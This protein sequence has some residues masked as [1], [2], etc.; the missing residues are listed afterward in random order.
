VQIEGGLMAGIIDARM[1]AEIEG[2]F[3]VF[4]IGFRINKFWKVWKW[5]PVFAAMPRMLI[6]L[7]K[8]PGAGLLH[9]RTHFGP[10]S[11]MVVQYWR[12]FDHLHAYSTDSSRAHLPAWKAFNRAVASNGDVGIWHETYLV[13][14][15]EYESVYNNMPAY[16]LGLAGQLHEASGKRRSA[17]GRL[18]QTEGD[19]QP[20]A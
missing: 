11:A 5:A 16:G 6:E 14:A 8:N 10:R 3:V 20:P 17:K 19:D 7:A 18:N 9:A 4:L 12:S 13:R 15:G 1:T 2:D